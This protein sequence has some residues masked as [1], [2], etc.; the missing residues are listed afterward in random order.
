MTEDEVDFVTYCI[1]KL[2][3]H[4][5]RD[6]ASVYC[7]LADAGIITGYIVPCYDVLHSFGEQYLMD[8]ITSCMRE[9]GITI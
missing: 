4:L 5:K 8:D 7:L 2:A 3:V 6:E 1:G 9:R